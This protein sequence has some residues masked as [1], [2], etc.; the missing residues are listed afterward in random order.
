MPRRNHGFTLLELLVVIAI[1]LALVVS[2]VPN[3]GAG[4]SGA[5]LAG[6]TRSLQQ[7]VRYAR[8]M[9]VLHQ[10]EVE[11]VLVTAGEG[12]R[13]GGGVRDGKP[14]PAGARIEVRV[15][16]S[17]MRR[18]RTDEVAKARNAGFSVEN[19]EEEPSIDT[20]DGGNPEADA[21]RERVVVESISLGVASTGEALSDLSKEIAASYPCGTAV[22]KLVRYTD[23]EDEDVEEDEEATVSSAQM[24]VAGSGAEEG[25]DGGEAEDLAARTMVFQ[26]DSDGLC[27]PFELRVAA[28]DEDDSPAFLLDIDRW[29]RVKIRESGDD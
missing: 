20:A 15:A 26:F 7:A 16:E 23:E 22:F 19:E 21:S 27:R 28:Y 29:G 6:A 14:D 9:A 1:I 5:G 3:I 24:I 2:V 11:L 12:A 8:T 10:V 17:A 4:F 25:A 18:A 13:N